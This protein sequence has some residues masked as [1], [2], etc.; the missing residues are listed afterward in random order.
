[1]TLRETLFGWTRRPIWCL[2]PLCLGVMSLGA[3]SSEAAPF[4]MVRV[5]TT[6]LTLGTSMDGLMS[7]AE[8]CARRHRKEKLAGSCAPEDLSIEL[9]S[10]PAISVPSFYLDRHEVSVADYQRCVQAG[11]CAPASRDQSAYH[12]ERP[13]LPVVFVSFDDASDYCRFRGARLPTEAQYEA[14]ARGTRG[15]TYPWGNFYHHGR[16]NAGRSG[17]RVTDDRDGHEL[18]APVHSFTDGRSPEGILNL[19]GNAAE[20][21]RSRFGPHGTA[22]QERASSHR[23]VKGGSFADDPIRLRS[24][25]RFAAP[26][27]TKTAQIGFRCARRVGPQS[28]ASDDKDP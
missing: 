6:A 1:M 7:A 26:S 2:G 16:A 28:S 19:S 20:W 27:G 25:A 9:S 11:R 4:G 24:S 17:A 18:L 14:A 15:R 23:V 13:D 5:P 21:T 12:F 10:G 3:S 8:A 22:H